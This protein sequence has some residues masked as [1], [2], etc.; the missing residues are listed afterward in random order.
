[1]LCLVLGVLLLAASP[2]GA[3][4]APVPRIGVLLFSDSFRPAFEGLRDGL[5]ELGFTEGATIR[6]DVHDLQR[7]PGRL[8]ELQGRFRSKPVTLVFTTTTPVAQQ[9]QRLDPDHSLPLVFTAVSSPLNSGIVDSL[10]HP[11]KNTTGVSHIS[12][13]T[14]P[15]RLMLFKTAFP[16]MR[17]VAVFFNP[18]EAFL[19]GHLERY[20]SRA[21]AEAGVEL[22]QVPVSG[23]EEMRRQVERL[24][25]S[26]I[27][28]I[29]MLPD[30]TSVALLDQ[31]QSLAS[32]ERLPLMV[33]DNSL[34]SRAGVIAYSPAFYDVGRQAAGMVAAILRGARAGSLPVQNPRRIRLVVSMREA[35]RLGL[36]PSDEILAQA[37]E[38]I[39]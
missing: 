6:F 4:E 33:V 12:F 7:D 32:R 1:M 20:L 17:R 11:G 35:N 26:R 28:G 19:Q 5:A 8:P 37:D 9:M 16:A 24:D 2:L 27:D 10:R 23:A 15:R 21:A 36:R 13:E 25:R 31:L 3:G 22:V 38:I 14:L 29:F 18:R 30:P 34:L 39:R